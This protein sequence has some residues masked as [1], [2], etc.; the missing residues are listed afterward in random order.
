ME[1]REELTSI[2][3]AGLRTGLGKLNPKRRRC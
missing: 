3:R 2:L 1:L